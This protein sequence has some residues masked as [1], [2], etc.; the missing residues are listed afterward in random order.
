LTALA[1]ALAV[2]S[3]ILAQSPPAPEPTVAVSTD[4]RDL[5]I[6]RAS[7][8]RPVRIPVLDRCGNPAVGEPKIRNI[9]R[10]KDV[11]IATFG[12]HCFAKVSLKTLGVDC[13]GCD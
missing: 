5:E 8:A 4:G 6:K 2:S 12:K 9:R 1:S 10:Q 13:A 11:V 3:E 7:D